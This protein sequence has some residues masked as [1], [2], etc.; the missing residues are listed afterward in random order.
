[1]LHS[2][3]SFRQ[4]FDGLFFFN[5]VSQCRVVAKP[6]DSCCSWFIDQCPPFN[7][8]TLT[9]R[10]TASPIFWDRVWSGSSNSSDF[11]GKILIEHLR[12]QPFYLAFSLY[13]GTG[14]SHS[15]PYRSKVAAL[16]FTYLLSNFIPT[17]QNSF[18]NYSI[19]SFGKHVIT[20]GNIL[21][22]HSCSAQPGPD[23]KQ[24]K[25]RWCRAA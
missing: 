3:L 20:D 21:S 6:M 16:H 1:M 18:G 24:E 19:S 25:K 22:S 12:A 13:L 8:Y 9:L 17:V 23:W 7:W 15:D 10:T 11:E 4:K 14:L 2:L 5:W